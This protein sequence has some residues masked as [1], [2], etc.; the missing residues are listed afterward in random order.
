MSQESYS[1]FGFADRHNI[2]PTSMIARATIKMIIHTQKGNLSHVFV[3]VDAPRNAP[4]R[5]TIAPAAFFSNINMS[6]QV[7]S[8]GRR[9]RYVAPLLFFDPFSLDSQCL[10][11]HF[12]Y[13]LFV[14][15]IS[16]ILTN[17]FFETPF[18]RHGRAAFCIN[19]AAICPRT[20]W[21]P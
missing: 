11:D 19:T 2:Y 13:S 16:P 15:M 17:L 6:S 3:R 12:S 7:W 4:I 18:P 8:H 14:T 5:K 10:V 9:V 1:V 21:E 20:I